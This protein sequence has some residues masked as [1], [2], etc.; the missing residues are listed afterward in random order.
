MWT[1][2]C[3]TLAIDPLLDNINDPVS[4]LQVCALRIRNGRYSRSGGSVR[5]ST[6]DTELRHVGQTLV[7][8]GTRDPRLTA[9]G[10]RDI[11]LSCQSSY[12]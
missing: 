7:L 8:L 11:R 3:A 2:Y 1:Q 5:A 6:V 12:W 9:N 10:K 4:L